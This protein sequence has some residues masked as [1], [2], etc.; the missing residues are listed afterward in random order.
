MEG[1]ILSAK[2]KA[3]TCDSNVITPGTPFMAILS[4]ALQYYI[5]SRLNHNPGWRY[6]KV[7][8]SDSNVP[9]E[10]EH[11]IMSYIRLQR[12]LP[13]FDPNTRHCLYGLDADL[14]MLSLATHEVHFSILREVITYPGQQEK[15][16]VCGQ[17][18][19]FASD[20]PG[21]SGS[22]NAAADIPIHKKKYQFLNIWVLREY[23][24][25]EL[26]IPDPPFMINF[27][28]I[29]DDFVFLCFFVGNDF[30]PHMP[31]LEIREGAI[32]LLMHVYR[33]EFTAMGGYLTDSGEVLLDRVEHFIQAVAVNEDKIFQKRTRIKQSMDNNEEMKQRSR[34]DPSEVPPEPIDDKIKLG[35]PGYKERY[36]AE[37][38]STTNPEETEQI[39]QDMVSFTSINALCHSSESLMICYNKSKVGKRYL[40]AMCYFDYVCI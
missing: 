21:K 32:N 10:G 38:F 26:A 19:H 16:F 15:C 12:N 34:R 6:V 13:G 31:T 5:Q 2:E 3:E 18:G 36:Y 20:C 23:L 30:L 1:Q 35:E 11:K 22:N 29:I 28:R 7:I 17:T 4:V 40:L 8:L 33:K 14:I 37:K 24:Q 39:K 25:Y 27:E 9:G